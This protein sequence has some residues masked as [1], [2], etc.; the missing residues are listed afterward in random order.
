MAV[1]LANVRTI[2]PPK[3]SDSAAGRRYSGVEGYA[4]VNRAAVREMHRQVGDL[5]ID[6]RGLATRGLL[7]RHL[8]LPGGLAVE[9]AP[10]GGLA[11]QEFF[12][13]VKKA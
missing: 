2:R 3:Y 11:M 7:V 5:L 1:P 13:G 12:I 8:V 9:S 10:G 4:E 6:D